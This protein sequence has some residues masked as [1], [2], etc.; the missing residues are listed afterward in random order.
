MKSRL[1]SASHSISASRAQALV[2][3]VSGSSPSG[4][5]ATFTSRPSPNTM[6]TPRMAARSPAGIAVKQHG[7]ALAEPPQ[8]S[9]PGQRSQRGA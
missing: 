7:H 1:F 8:Q 9:A 5:T 2:A 3:K 6:S 4:S